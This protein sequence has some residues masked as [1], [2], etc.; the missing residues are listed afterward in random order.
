[1]RTLSPFLRRH[2]QGQSR[3]F[4]K[5]LLFHTIHSA[6]PFSG[7]DPAIQRRVDSKDR[8]HVAAW[9]LNFNQPKNLLVN[10]RGYRG[11]LVDKSQRRIKEETILLSSKWR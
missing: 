7:I 4:R 5:R 8:E 2:A 6:A 1:M 3:H 9:V 10:S 11:P